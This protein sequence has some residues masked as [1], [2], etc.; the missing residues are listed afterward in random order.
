MKKRLEE[1]KGRWPEELPNVLWSYRTTAHTST[2]HTPFALAYGWEAML[3]VEVEVPT[4]RR[5]TYNQ[6]DNH[7]LLE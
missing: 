7:V 2:G 3:P 1:A 6:D 4:R 5:E